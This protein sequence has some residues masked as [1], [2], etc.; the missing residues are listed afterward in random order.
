M[1]A[2]EYGQHPYGYGYSFLQLF[3]WRLVTTAFTAH[4]KFAYTYSQLNAIN[5]FSITLRLII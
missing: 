2:D 5:L 3:V 4:Y 1:E